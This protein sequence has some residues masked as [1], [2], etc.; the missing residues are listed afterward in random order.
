MSWES[1]WINKK[2][3]DEEIKSSLA[4]LLLTS[5]ELI[6]LQSEQLTLDTVD[7]HIKIVC[8]KFKYRGD[9]P[10]ML[11]LIFMD[12]SLIPQDKYGFIGNLCKLLK[13]NCLV[14]FPTGSP[15]HFILIEDYGIYKK[16]ALDA[17]LL[18]SEEPSDAQ[19]HILKTIKTFVSE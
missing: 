12:L 2:V 15:Y 17:D 16:V 7:N 9:F 13:C 6:I 1:I 4:K 3:T 5:Q 10:I 14:T 8:G 19:L 18:D 11:E